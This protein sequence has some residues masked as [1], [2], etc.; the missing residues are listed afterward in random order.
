ME[1]QKRFKGRTSCINKQGFIEEAPIKAQ[2]VR[3]KFLLNNSINSTKQLSYV[4]DN[5]TKVQESKTI[6]IFNRR[7]NS[8]NKF[9]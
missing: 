5:N 1:F 6:I 8:N 2:P 7:I 4:L 3:Q 9:L